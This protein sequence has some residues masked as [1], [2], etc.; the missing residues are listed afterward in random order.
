MLKTMK[1]QMLPERGAVAK[2]KLQKLL[3]YVM[4]PHSE[5]ESR[6]REPRNAELFSQSLCADKWQLIKNSTFFSYIRLVIYTNKEFHKW[7][8]IGME[9]CK[10]VMNLEK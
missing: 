10:L 4:L 9:K 6:S 2:A 5:T 3:C 1:N 8:Q 7:K